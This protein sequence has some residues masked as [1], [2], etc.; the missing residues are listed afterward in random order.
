MIFFWLQLIFIKNFSFSGW[1]EPTQA[2]FFTNQPVVKIWKMFTITFYT[3]MWNLRALW[4]VVALDLLEYRYMNNVTGNLFSLLCSA[5]WAVLKMFVRLFR[6][7]QVKAS[8][9]AGAIYKEEKQKEFLTIWEKNFSKT[10]VTSKIK[11]QKK[12]RRRD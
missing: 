8:S 10:L 1:L 12:A 7:K 6:I 11:K 5:W 3:M 9:L 2:F 4:L